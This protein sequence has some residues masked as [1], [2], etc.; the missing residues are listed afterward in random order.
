MGSYLEAYGSREALRAKRVR[1]IKIVSISVVLA[2]VVGAIL[3]SS[4]RNYGE[5]SQVKSF[6]QLLRNGQYQDAYIMFGCTESTPCPNY[7]FPKFR[8]DWG[9]QSAH[10]DAASAS[11]G[12]AESCGSGVL[13][14]VVYPHA[15]TVAL[16]VERGS[17][18]IGFAPWN[19]CHGRHWH[20]GAF[21][22][23]LVGK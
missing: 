8:D 12:D 19:Q 10:A 17:R 22:K 5:E 4:F 1:L 15:D 18:T 14:Q 6:L 3:Y 23:S 7:P 20:I 16:W 21:L 9:P 13:V 11:A 2:F